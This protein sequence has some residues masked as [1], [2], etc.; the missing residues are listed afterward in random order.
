MPSGSIPSTTPIASTI[1]IRKTWKIT[2]EFGKV[3]VQKPLSAFSIRFPSTDLYA[4]PPGTTIVCIQATLS[5]GHIHR[6]EILS[7]RSIFYSDFGAQGSY[8]NL[9]QPS[10]TSPKVD[11]K[12]TGGGASVFG[13][14]CFWRSSG[15]TLR[16]SAPSSFVSDSRTSRGGGVPNGPSAAGHLDPE[17]RS[18]R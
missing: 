9:K 14:S 7:T 13:P 12:R 17:A 4:G 15:S 6:R 18:S 3:I 1:R 5:R 16:A 2:N 10:S 11:R 8:H